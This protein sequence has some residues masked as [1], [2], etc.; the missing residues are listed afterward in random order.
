MGNLDYASPAKSSL[1]TNT[2]IVSIVSHY[3]VY[4]HLTALNCGSRIYKQ[5]F[6]ITVT[7]CFFIVKHN[8]AH[9]GLP[10]A[11]F[12]SQLFNPP[13]AHT[14]DTHALP[15]CLCSHAQCY[16]LACF[17][18]FD[19]ACSQPSCPAPALANCL[20]FCLAKSL[21]APC[22]FPFAWHLLVMELVLS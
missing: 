18:G 12:G 10:F 9:L 13:P 2:V 11:L 8:R 17:P 6:M 15:D 14:P 5:Y 21:P 16:S 19:L 1:H 3:A 22:L 4:S 7:V 20:Y